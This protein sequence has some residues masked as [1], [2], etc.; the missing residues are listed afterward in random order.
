MFLLMILQKRLLPQTLQPLSSS[1]TPK[2]IEQQMKQFYR[3]LHSL[4]KIGERE[5][6]ARALLTLADHQDNDELKAIQVVLQKL[7]DNA[8][9]LVGLLQ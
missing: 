1:L 8:C 9:A 4:T 5:K 3:L 6:E 7:T 2:Q